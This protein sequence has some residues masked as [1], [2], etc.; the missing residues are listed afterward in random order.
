MARKPIAPANITVTLDPVGRVLDGSSTTHSAGGEVHVTG[1]KTYAVY[2]SR[3]F[4][5]RGTPWTVKGVHYYAA[6]YLDGSTVRAD[7]LPE[8]R[9]AAVRAFKEGL[10]DY[11]AAVGE[12]TAT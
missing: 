9:A 10:A 6:L 8:L 12:R 7:A 4:E 3:I 5:K 1:G 11:C 2:V